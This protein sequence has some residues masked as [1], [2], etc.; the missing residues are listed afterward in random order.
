MNDK[1]IVDS[2]LSPF[3]RMI[4][5]GYKIEWL[6]MWQANKIFDPKGVYIGAYGRL[7]DIGEAKASYMVVSAITNAVAVIN[8]IEET[9]DWL[10]E[11]AN[12]T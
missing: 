6:K 12:N 5:A 3:T 11:Q 7:E 4:M 9:F 1:E 2:I 10:K 8:G